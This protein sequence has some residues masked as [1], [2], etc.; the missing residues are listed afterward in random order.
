MQDSYRCHF[1]GTPPNIDGRLED[2][3]WNDAPEVKFYLPVTHAQP[4]SLTIGRVL[5]DEKYLYV[6]I[7]AHDKDVWSYFTERDSTTCFE[8]VLEIFLKPRTG[9]DSYYNFEINALGTV[10][11]AFNMKRGAGGEDHH[12]WSRWNCEGLRVATGVKGTMNKPEDEDEYW[13]LEVAIPFASLPSLQGR[14]PQAG[15]KWRFHLSRYDYS[16]YL[17]EGVE[18]SSSAKFTSTTGSFFHRW[19]EW[20]ELE[21]VR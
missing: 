11:D 13:T 6:G 3:V 9:Q 20:P 1:T 15:E 10:Y 16:I 8:D 14:P 18:L 17:K 7:K 4:E 12:R 5:W 21:F 19:E 2:P